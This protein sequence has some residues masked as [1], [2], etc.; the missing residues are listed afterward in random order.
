MGT[1]ISGF[2][3][4]PKGRGF[5]PTWFNPCLKAIQMVEIVGAGTAVHFSPKDLRLNAGFSSLFSNSS[6]LNFLDC[7]RTVRTEFID[8][9]RAVRS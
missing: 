3:Q 1:K 2:R 7:I 8:C 5:S 9:F 4:T 6:K